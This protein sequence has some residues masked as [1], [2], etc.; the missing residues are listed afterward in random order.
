MIFDLV[1]LNDMVKIENTENVRTNIKP[2]KNEPEDDYIE[3]LESDIKKQSELFD[4]FG[5]KAPN[6]LAFPGGKHK[7]ISNVVL[8]MNGYDATITTNEQKT[9]TLVCGL[10][11][12]LINLGRLNVAEYTT[13]TQILDYLK[14]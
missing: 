6:I 5:L 1:N 8:R 12:S 13:D 7:T 3:A 14:R 10:S 2:F 11:Q 9:N 4:S